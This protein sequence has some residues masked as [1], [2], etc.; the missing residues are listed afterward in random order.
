MPEE[1]VESVVETNETVETA[2]ETP[3]VENEEPKVFDADYVKGLREEAAKH[4]VEKQKEAQA[5]IELEAKLKEYEDAKLSVEEK[6]AR[7]FQE[8]VSKASVF[9]QMAT[10]SNLK[11]QLAVAASEFGIVDLNAAVK[12]AD[13]ELIQ[14]DGNGNISNITEIVESLQAEYKSLFAS[15]APNVPNTRVTN[16]SKVP[17]AKK[18]TRDDIV[19]M[20]PERRVELLEKGELNHLL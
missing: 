7:D 1:T 4:R 17:A 9:E 12:L 3:K 10:E 2:V 8:A 6:T 20:S 15:A 11:Y 14:T 16:P 13:R 19:R 5:R 18:Y